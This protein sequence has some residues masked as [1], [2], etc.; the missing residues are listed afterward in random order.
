[1]S[2][3]ATTFFMSHFHCSSRHLELWTIYMTQI[4]HMTVVLK[5]T[6]SVVELKN[7]WVQFHSHIK[8]LGRFFIHMPFCLISKQSSSSFERSRFSIWVILGIWWKSHSIQKNFQYMFNELWKFEVRKRYKKLLE[9]Q[10]LV[11]FI[12]NKYCLEFLA[13]FT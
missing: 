10:S 2:N 11:C 7:I 4:W 9:I 8:Y 6:N 12:L 3:S 13:L 1:M 5:I